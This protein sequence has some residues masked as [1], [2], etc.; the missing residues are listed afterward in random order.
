MVNK[1]EISIRDTNLRKNKKKE[2][3]NNERRNEKKAFPYAKT[4]PH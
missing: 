2:N 3:S 1:G 4:L